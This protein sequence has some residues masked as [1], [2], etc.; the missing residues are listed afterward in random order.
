MA[1]ISKVTK[2][3]EVSKPPL[4]RW[5]QLPLRPKPKENSPC[6]MKTPKTM[7]SVHSSKT[8]KSTGKPK[9]P[10]HGIPGSRT[11]KTPKSTG[12][13]KTPSGCR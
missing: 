3:P 13:Q 6:R 2:L 1:D 8:P 11:S 4:Q 12:K 5:Q 7:R 9:T 10:V